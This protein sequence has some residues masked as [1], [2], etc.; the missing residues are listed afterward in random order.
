MGWNGKGCVEI[1]Y[2]ISWKDYVGDKRVDAFDDKMREEV[3]AFIEKRFE[4]EFAKEISTGEI[5]ITT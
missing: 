1:R 3:A 5:M 2:S 4:E